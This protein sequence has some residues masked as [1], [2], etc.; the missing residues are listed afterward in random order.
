MLRALL[1]VLMAM[2]VLVVGHGSARADDGVFFCKTVVDGACAEWSSVIDGMYA[3]SELGITPTAIAEC[4]GFG[5]GVVILCWVVGYVAGLS[6]KAS[7][8]ALEDH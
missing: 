4:M 1:S 8:D 5:F 3:L 2:A 7:A 6:L